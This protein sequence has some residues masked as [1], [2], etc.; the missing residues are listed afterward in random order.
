M[1]EDA[2]G[3]L[4]TT[5]LVSMVVACDAMLKTAQ[6]RLVSVERIGC[7]VLTASIRGDVAAVRAALDAGSAAAARLGR[8]A[9][10]TLLAAPAPEL[11][12]RFPVGPGPRKSEGDEFV[13][14]C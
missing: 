10:V 3:L 9:V 1:P 4:E 7:A 14:V 6:V 11:S 12:G 13:C 8:P 5:S 2:L